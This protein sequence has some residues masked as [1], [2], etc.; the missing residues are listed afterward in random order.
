MSLTAISPCPHLSMERLTARSAS[1][2][3]RLSFT[4]SAC[5]MRGRT[6]VR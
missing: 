6:V 1:E 4:R 5:S 3:T 2:R